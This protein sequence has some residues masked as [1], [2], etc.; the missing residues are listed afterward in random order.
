M[1]N[2]NDYFDDCCNSNDDDNYND[3]DNHDN[4]VGNNDEKDS[5]Y[6]GCSSTHKSNK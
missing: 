2:Y 6:F 4:D 1:T 5:A 3:D